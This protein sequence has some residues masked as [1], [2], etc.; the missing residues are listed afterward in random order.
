METRRIK[1]P[2]GVQTF[3]RIIKENYVYVD[4]TAY[5]YQLANEMPKYLFLSRPRRFGK[6]LLLSTLKSYFEGDKDLFKGLAIEK[7]ERKWESYPVIHLSLAGFKGEDASL[8]RKYLENEFIRLERQYGNYGRSENFGVSLK[9]LIEH[10]HI[11]TGKDVVVLIDEYDNPLLCVVHNEEKRDAIQT[12]VTELYATLKDCDP[13]LK[14]VFITGITKFSQLSIFSALNNITNISMRDEFAAICGITNEELRTQMREGIESLSD[15]MG[16]EIDEALS[17][18]KERYDG[19]KFTP[20]GMEIY[21]PYSLIKCF[22]AN[23]IR[24]YWF[25][26]GTQK[27]VIQVLN[28]Y[29]VVPSNIGEVQASESDFDC[30]T[31]DMNSWI[32]LFYQSGYLT[33]KDLNEKV[34]LYTLDIPNMEVRTGLMKSLLTDYIKNPVMANNIVA[35]IMLCFYDGNIEKALDKLTVFFESVPY[36]N[37]IDYEGHWQQMLYVVFSLFGAYADV[38]V[39]ALKGRVDMAM[40]FMNHLYLFEVKLNG[41][42]QEAIDQIDLKDYS[43]RFKLLNYPIVK[44]GIAFDTTQR[45]IID[46]IVKI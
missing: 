2:V 12:V 40:I 1:Y 35:Q 24:D 25:E 38:E 8:L 5:V 4:K 14:F 11:T 31:E 10:L 30:P 15:K 36:C 6:S 34:D 41:T 29:H 45:T 37:N 17:Q 42:A 28:K 20:H 22:E 7:L 44:V 16:V 46:K 32:P 43:K 21:N 27:Y 13:W 39:H 3:S 19:Y 26:T 9:N 18:L 23:K 33:I